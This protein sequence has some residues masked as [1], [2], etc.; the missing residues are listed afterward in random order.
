MQEAQQSQECD[1][2]WSSFPDLD[3]GPCEVIIV[4]CFTAQKDA[5]VVHRSLLFLV[6]PV[7]YRQTLAPPHPTFPFPSL[8]VIPLL[9][10]CP[11]LGNS[12]KLCIFPDGFFANM[13]PEAHEWTPAKIVLMNIDSRIEQEGYEGN[14]KISGFPSGPHSSNGRQQM[15]G[16]SCSIKS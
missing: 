9:F 5:T 3:M 15:V 14:L 4:S 16:F 2:T 6:F 13:I 8:C 1:N 11:S 12:H 10:F 7:V